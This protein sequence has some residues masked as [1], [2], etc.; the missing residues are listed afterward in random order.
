MT[1]GD[2]NWD[3][4]WR[5]GFTYGP[6]D[7]WAREIFLTIGE[8]LEDCDSPSILSAGCGRG[9]IDY[10]ILEALGCRVTLLDNS[11]Q[12][13][14]NLKKLLRKV[15]GGRYEIVYGSIQD[16]H[17]PN[18]SF[19][20]V[21]NEG[22]LEHFHEADYRRAFRE[23]VRVARRYVLTDVPNANCRPY[24]LVKEWVDAHGKWSWGYEQP[25]GSLRQDLEDCGVQL[26]SE[27]SI[28]GH[29]TIMNY[30]DMVPFEHRQGILNRL[31]PEDF[32]TFPHLLT[33][34]VLDV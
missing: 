29:R 26:L 14:K 11:M 27:K 28:G 33:I 7:G 5:Q 32:E 24:I 20:L 16:I 19:D 15:E 2:A 3:K 22:A 1:S 9:L 13:I 25:R 6:L 12:C 30:L 17:F 18:R 21:W 8:L 4:L 34:G 23:M 31:E 10:W